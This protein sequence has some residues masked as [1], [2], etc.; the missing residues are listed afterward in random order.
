MELMDLEVASSRDHRVA[1]SSNLSLGNCLTS[2]HQ[3]LEKVFIVACQAHP[4]LVFLL[5]M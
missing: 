5:K 1:V 3:L 4:A 2:A